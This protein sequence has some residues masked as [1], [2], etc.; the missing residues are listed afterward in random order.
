MGDILHLTSNLNSISSQ[1][2][3]GYGPILSASE[4]AAGFVQPVHSSTY[5]QVRVKLGINPPYFM[6]NVAFLT[7]SFGR[8]VFTADPVS[9]TEA[10]LQA[11]RGSGDDVCHHII[12]HCNIL[13][14]RFS[15]LDQV[16]HKPDQVIHKLDQ[17]LVRPLDHTDIKFVT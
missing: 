6:G 16:I 5:G 14:D 3:G 9:A 15:R 10:I 11:V 17:Y 1:V 8:A 7:I 2:T 4:H 13:A 12:G